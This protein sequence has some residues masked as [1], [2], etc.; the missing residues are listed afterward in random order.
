MSCDGEFSQFTVGRVSSAVCLLSHSG[1]WEDLRANLSRIADWPSN[2]IVY[3]VYVS[4]HFLRDAS[5]PS[6]SEIR[7]VSCI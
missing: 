4:F 7:A 6:Q 1:G 5:I 2:A 3:P